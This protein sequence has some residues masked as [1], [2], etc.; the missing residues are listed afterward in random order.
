MSFFEPPPRPRR[1]QTLLDEAKTC[2]A[3]YDNDTTSYAYRQHKRMQDESDQDVYSFQPF[4]N[5]W[6]MSSCTKSLF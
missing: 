5:T 2:P 4:C 3:A 1:R 6:D